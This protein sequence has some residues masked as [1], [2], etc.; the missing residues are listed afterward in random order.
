[1][2]IGERNWVWNN[3][4]IARQGIDVHRGGVCQTFWRMTMAK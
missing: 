1:M 3:G 2:I 4:E